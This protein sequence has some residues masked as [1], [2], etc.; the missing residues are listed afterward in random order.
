MPD[1]EHIYAGSSRLRHPR[2]EGDLMQA[3]V[4]AFFLVV[5][6]DVSDV[7]SLPPGYVLRSANTLSMMKISLE[8][9]TA[10]WTVVKNGRHPV[11]ISVRTLELYRPL[12][13]YVNAREMAR[14]NLSDPKIVL[15]LGTHPD[16]NRHQVGVI[17][18]KLVA[19]RP[20]W[21]RPALLTLMNNLLCG[22]PVV[23]L[24]Q[25]RDDALLQLAPSVFYHIYAC[26]PLQVRFFYHLMTKPQVLGKAYSWGFEQVFKLGLLLT[27]A[28]GAHLTTVKPHAIAAITPQVMAKMKPINLR[29]LTEQ[30][31]AKLQPNVRNILRKK[32]RSYTFIRRGISTANTPQP[33]LFIMLLFHTSVKV[34]TKCL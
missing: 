9:L 34:L 20:G 28:R 27:E 1:L 16:L 31:K 3:A 26:D 33:L 23:L 12:F 17:A 30:Q 29:Y 19:L 4:D 8:K 6:G 5:H 21:H 18:R 11:D 13:K 32:L 22:L 10:L 14:L 15:Y 25:I 7:M 2:S 24:H